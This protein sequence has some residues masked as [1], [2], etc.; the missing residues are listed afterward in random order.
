VR[1]EEVDAGEFA[2][3]G[4]VIVQ[5]RNASER[6]AF[7]FE[8]AV[9]AEPGEELGFELRRLPPDA[10]DK[11]FVGGGFARGFGLVGGEQILSEHKVVGE[12]FGRVEVELDGE[13]WADGLAGVDLPEVGV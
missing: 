3:G 5:R 8:L 2:C 6:G 12:A 9:A 4:G 1:G 11:C 13:L 7:R 10:A